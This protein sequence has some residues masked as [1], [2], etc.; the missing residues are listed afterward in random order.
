MLCR[1]VVGV[2][3]NILSRSVCGVSSV[4][5]GALPPQVIP[6]IHVIW[7]LGRISL[8]RSVN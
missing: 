8:M 5:C 4:V 6:H 2:S 1:L 7:F 3:F